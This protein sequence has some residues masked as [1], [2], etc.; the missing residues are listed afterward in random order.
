MN[1]ARH[2]GNDVDRVASGGLDL[3]D[4]ELLRVDFIPIKRSKTGELSA[5][6]DIVLGR[7]PDE[8][9]FPSYRVANRSGR[10]MESPELS[11]NPWRSRESRR[12]YTPMNGSDKPMRMIGWL[13]R[14]LGGK[15]G[16]DAV[17]DWWSLTRP[18]GW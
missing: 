7:T 11:E 5:W 9:A 3:F 6:F 1:I 4:K 18:R 15:G 12:T 13:V 2:P 10:D 17:A 8:R 16:R 14:G